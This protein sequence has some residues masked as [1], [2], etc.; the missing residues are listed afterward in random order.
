MPLALRYTLLFFAVCAAHTCS[1]QGSLPLGDSVHDILFSITT[2]LMSNYG[3]LV[4]LAV[5]LA[6]AMF[7]LSR[8]SGWWVFLPALQFGVLPIFTNWLWS[9]NSC[10]DIPWNYLTFY[11]VG[12]AVFVMTVCSGK[13]CQ[14][15]TAE[16]H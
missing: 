9:T 11:L 2:C 12:T 13:Q 4:M 5:S 7:I 14:E 6:S 3:R 10:H 16:L 8:C 1:Q 15:E